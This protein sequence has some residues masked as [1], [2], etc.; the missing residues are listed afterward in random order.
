MARYPLFGG[1]HLVALVALGTARLALGRVRPGRAF[2]VR[3]VKL[4]LP[5]RI[6]S[7]GEI[8]AGA[9]F[10]DGA[11]DHL[12]V[13]GRQEQRAVGAGL[14]GGLVLIARLFLGRFREILR[15]GRPRAA[16]AARAVSVPV[17]PQ[18]KK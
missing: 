2:S 11:L 17:N 12:A 5:R 3:A 10:A 7:L 15:P 1:L 14:G 16:S 6:C 8:T 18:R 9:R 13:I 4:R